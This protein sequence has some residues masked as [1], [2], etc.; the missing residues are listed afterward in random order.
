MSLSIFKT[1]NNNSLT[2]WNSQ[3]KSFP[4][5]LLNVLLQFF[6][7]NFSFLKI[8]LKSKTQKPSHLKSRPWVLYTQGKEAHRGAGEETKQQ[9]GQ[10]LQR[11]GTRL[12]LP[13]ELI[14]GNAERGVWG[15]QRRGPGGFNQWDTAPVQRRECG[16]KRKR[17]A[18]SVCVCVCVHMCMGQRWRWRVPSIMSYYM[19]EGTSVSLI[20]RF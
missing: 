17:N 13:Y 15:P 14:V 18:D 19:R 10:G 1:I 5:L 20:L 9:R 8:F 16:V 6:S 7:S 3:W 4:W 11:R 2:A 12:G